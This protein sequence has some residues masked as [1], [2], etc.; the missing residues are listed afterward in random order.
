MP[1]YGVSTTADLEA[2]IQV[3]NERDW[4]TL[5]EK[6]MAEDCVWYAS[7]QPLEGKQELVDYWT[8]SHSA[9]QETL[10]EPEQAVYGDGKIYLQVKIQMRF[11]KDG[12]FLGTPYQKG[13]VLDLA[14]A[15]YYELN[16]E[17]KINKGVVYLKPIY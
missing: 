7:E 17:G 3:F 16:S 11:L 4:D 1:G 9:I 12:S 15:D 10:G 8:Q 14:C 5:F 6:Y 13:G 2:L